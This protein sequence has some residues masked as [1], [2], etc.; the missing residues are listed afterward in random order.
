MLGSTFADQNSKIN[1]ISSYEGEN[2]NIFPLT[3]ADIYKRKNL[4]INYVP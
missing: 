3:K 4:Q 1:T 2:M